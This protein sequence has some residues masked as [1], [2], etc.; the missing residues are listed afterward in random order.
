MVNNFKTTQ[1]A[2]RKSVRIIPS[3]YPPIQV[4]EDIA[5]EGDWDLLAA[6]EMAVNPRLRDQKG[7][8]SLVLPEDRVGGPGSTW[9]MA[10]F[11]HINQMGSRFSDGSYGLYYAGY[12][13]ETA[14]LETVYH[15]E[16][17]L[18]AGQA[19]PDDMDQRVILADI[20][21]QAVNLIEATEAAPMMNP[22]DYKV[23]QAFGVEHKK[24]GGEAI[25]FASVR[26]PG[27]AAIAV[28]KPRLISN[29]TQAG[30]LQ[31]HW[32]GKRISKFF[33]YDSNEWTNFA[34]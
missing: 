6:L 11:T 3:K 4:F 29:A 17:R 22:N 14:L 7:K 27:A 25:L 23:S 20:E 19:A 1:I 31:Y 24:T 30:H 13:F 18:I 16:Q 28:F 2:W 26:N 34:A 5:E 32:D 12:E 9:I 33:D 21:C 10:P 15:L 8:I